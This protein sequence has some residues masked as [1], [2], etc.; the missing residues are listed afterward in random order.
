MD[1]GLPLYLQA[2]GPVGGQWGG[3]GGMDH[4][5]PLYLQARRSGDCCRGWQRLH[6]SPLPIL[7]PH[8]Q[9]R[10]QC[11]VRSAGISTARLRFLHAGLV[12][13]AAAVC[14]GILAPVDGSTAAAATERRDGLPPQVGDG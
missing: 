4:G 12:E 6:S 3:G 9:E 11:R 13:A 1:H 14:S 2:R 8:P 7:P 5:L 10:A